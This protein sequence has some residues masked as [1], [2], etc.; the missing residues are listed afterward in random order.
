MV[1]SGDILSRGM[2][3]TAWMSFI[4]EVLYHNITK[5][6][7][8]ATQAVVIAQRKVG[9]DAPTLYLCA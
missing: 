9:L 1:E 8:N 3:S 5:Q 6:H 2:A 7:K 4:S